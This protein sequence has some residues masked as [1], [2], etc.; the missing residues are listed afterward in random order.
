[1]FRK[2]IFVAV[3]LFVFCEVIVPAFAQDNTG[4]TAEKR[5]P[6]EVAKTK[7][8]SNEMPGNPAAIPAAIVDVQYDNCPLSGEKVK[9]EIS[10]IFEGKIYHFCSNDCLNSFQKDPKA[11]IAKIKDAK[12]IPLTITNLDGKCPATGEKASGEVFIVR[13]DKITFYCC[14][15]CIGKDKLPEEKPGK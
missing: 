6:Q 11:V 4:N 10:A 1:M 14:P 7:A 12:E 15:S 8:P 3:C 5:R 9:P 13:G 2:F